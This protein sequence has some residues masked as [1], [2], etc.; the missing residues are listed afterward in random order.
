MDKLF[1]RKE[2]VMS[3]FPSGAAGACRLCFPM[4]RSEG[5][6]AGGAFRQP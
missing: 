5:F 1:A 3:A 2:E 4:E 6:P